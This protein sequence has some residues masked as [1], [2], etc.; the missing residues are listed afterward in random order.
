METDGFTF[1]GYMPSGRTAG[2]QGLS[3]F[4]FP[5]YIPRGWI[6][7]SGSL[8]V[9]HFEELSSCFPKWPHNFT[10]SPAVYK[11]SNFSTSS[12]PLITCPSTI[13]WKDHSFVPPNHPDSTVKNPF[14]I[15]VWISGLLHS[16]PLIYMCLFLPW[17][18]FCLDCH[19]LVVSFIS[20]KCVSNSV[21]V[22]H[23]CFGYSGSLAF[24]Y[25]FY[26]QLVKFCK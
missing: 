10:Y 26:N 22:F 19:S 25:E 9:Q 17:T 3:V 20:G 12:L 15:N 6:A 5:G 13:C 16:I 2:S 24:L 14:T 21:L 11:G 4:N 7:G 18:T 1:P 23:N 8:Y